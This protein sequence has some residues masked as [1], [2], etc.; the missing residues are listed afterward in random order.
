MWWWFPLT[1]F[2][3]FSLKG[4]SHLQPRYHFASADRTVSR[5][6]LMDGS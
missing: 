1:L 5:G 2:Y 3:Q 6:E 4:S